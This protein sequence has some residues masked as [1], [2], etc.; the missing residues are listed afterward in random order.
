VNIPTVIIGMAALLFGIYTMYVRFTNPKKPG[1]KNN[2]CCILRISL[3]EKIA[4][5]THT[6]LIHIPFLKKQNKRNI[7][8]TMIKDLMGGKKLTQVIKDNNG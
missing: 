4:M 5:K 8:K 6:V 3:N 2:L 7:A 1:I